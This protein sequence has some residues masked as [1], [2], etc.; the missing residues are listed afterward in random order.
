MLASLTQWLSRIGAPRLRSA[1]APEGVV[2]YAI[3]DIHGRL[4]LFERL[5]RQ[6]HTDLAT[7]APDHRGVIVLLGDYVDRGPQ[8]RGVIEAIV[9]LESA[10]DLGVIALKGNHEDAMLRFLDNPVDGRNWLSFGG[11]ETLASYGVEAPHVLELETAVTPLRDAL[12]AALPDHHLAFLNRLPT[13]AIEQDY[14]FAHAGLRPGVP[15]DRQS[16]IDLMWRRSPGRPGPSTF[17]KVVVHGH[18]P[19][20]TVHLDADTVGVDT[21][22]YATDILTAIRLQGRTRKLIQTLD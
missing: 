13:M 15:I 2:I 3:G 5:I 6:I 22:A 11:L 9:Q 18:T 20:R 19:T 16:D 21:G 10:G 1:A 8:S 7:T 12:A 14:V 17:D 4:D